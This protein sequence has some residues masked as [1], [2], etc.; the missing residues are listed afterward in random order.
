MRLEIVQYVKMCIE[1]TITFNYHSQNFSNWGTPFSSRKGVLPSSV[2]VL[3]ENLS[4]FSLNLFKQII[5]VAY[6]AILYEMSFAV[7]CVRRWRGSTT[8]AVFPVWKWCV[9]CCIF[10]SVYLKTCLLEA[11]VNPYSIKI[12]N[13][14]RLKLLRFWRF[15]CSFWCN[16]FN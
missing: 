10:L 5:E 9:S 11:V 4:W 14:L 13:T 16:K 12:I 3:L 8:S 1:N 7:Y 6:I 2:A 15:Y